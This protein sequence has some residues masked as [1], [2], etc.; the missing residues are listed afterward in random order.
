M[1]LDGGKNFVI[2][3]TANG[4]S[5]A[6]QQGS[7][8]IFITGADHVIVRNFNIVSIYQNG[9]GSPSATDTGGNGTADIQ[10]V[11]PS[12]NIAIYNNTLNSSRI[13]ISSDTSSSSGPNNCPT[14]NGTIGVTTRPPD[15]PRGTGEFVTTTIRSQ[16]TPG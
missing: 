7:T 5:L 13:G 8:G 2:Q 6:N 15:R 9:G 16:I 10:V 14:P 1:I 4:T 11:G 12:T 3:N